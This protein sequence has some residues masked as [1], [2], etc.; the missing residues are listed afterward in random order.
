MEDGYYHSALDDV[1]P[2][3]VKCRSWF[4][5]GLAF[6]SG[7]CLLFA[8]IT[9]VSGPGN[10]PTAESTSL[11]LFQLPKMMDRPL[12]RST[13]ARAD[14]P[15]S[16]D[17]FGAMPTAR[18]GADAEDMQ[19]V[20]QAGTVGSVTPI[21]AARQATVPRSQLAR[22]GPVAVPLL[23]LWGLNQASTMNVPADMLGTDA[24][25][26]TKAHGSCSLSVPANIRWGCDRKMADNICCFNR[27]FAEPSGYFL[28][29]KFLSQE[30]P[31]TGTT[32]VTF[33]DTMTAK[34]LF[35]AP[36]GR[37][38][39]EFV[40]ESKVHGWPSFRDS[41][42]VQENVRVLSGGETVSNDGTHLGHNIPDLNGNRY[43]INLVS[44]AGLP[45]IPP[46][47]NA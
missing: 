18:F 22:W 47:S 9:A 43:C 35:V 40:E 15:S 45:P 5:V 37:T 14:G 39:E 44:I 31:G 3:P 21:Q 2:Q 8:T 26:A 25:M 34:P 4:K 32:E 6:I 19:A 46:D 30:N 28:N 36:R 23:G 24:L 41:E 13:F 27:N 38:W 10:I 20:G 1:D 7:C 11:R 33:Y 17:S 29:T 16:A 12:A 42:V